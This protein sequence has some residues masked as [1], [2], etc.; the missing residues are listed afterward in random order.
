VT[1]ITT[2]NKL[3]SVKERMIKGSKIINSEARNRIKIVARIIL[4]KTKIKARI[5]SN[6]TIRTTNLCL[7]LIL[8]PSK[9]SNKVDRRLQP[10]N[11][12]MKEEDEDKDAG[13]AVARTLRTRM[14]KLDV[15][16]EE[17]ANRTGHTET[18]TSEKRQIETRH[19][20]R[21]NL[22]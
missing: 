5:N 6:E 16:E 13:K 19:T 11:Q 7:S 18:T 20:L 14:K 9:K 17:A 10:K 22:I 21:R 15:R 4:I 12:T 2:K 3:I 8:T 1:K